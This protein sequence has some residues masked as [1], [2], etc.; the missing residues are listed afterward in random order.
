M[1]HESVLV[2]G[3]TGFTGGH[4]CRGLVARGYQV[5]A[6]VRDE[7]RAG[8]LR[9]LG[10]EL[11]QGDL[12]DPAALARAVNNVQTVYHI[13]ALFRQESVSRQIMWETNAEGVRKL[14]DAAIAANVARFVHCSTVGVHGEIKQPPATE[15]SPYGP[16]DDYQESKTAGEKIALEY[17]EAG[18][19][20]ITIFRPGGIY[21]PGDLRFLKLFRGIKRRKF[22]MFGSGQVL[23]QLIYIDDLVEGIIRCGTQAAAVGEVYIL[24]GAAPVTLNQ[25]VQQIAAVV[26]VPPPRLRLPVLPLYL[27]GFLCEVLCKP[28]GIE[29]PLYRRR[30][31]FFRK[32]RAFSIQKAQTQLSFAPKVD[33]ADGLRQTAAWYLQEGLL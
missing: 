6:L 32:D 5:R 33:L 29:P 7:Q 11:I 2:T 3:A 20:P 21:G 4:L 22:I 23:Y 31:D 19:L 24:T 13:A 15:T 12:R 30:V 18:R 16:G 1:A 25:L 10:V 28:L 17:M 26:A 27:A 8:D 14:L 9:Q